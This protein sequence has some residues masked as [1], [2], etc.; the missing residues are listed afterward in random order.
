M[1]RIHL[2]I[3]LLL[4]STSSFAQS[5]EIWEIQSNTTLSPYA[6]S[7]VTSNEN[8]VTA[9]G[10]DRF[11]IQCPTDR[12][13]NNPLT[14]DGMM[15][16]T[17]NN[18]PQVSVG[19]L[20]DVSGLVI[21][22]QALTEFTNQGLDYEIVGTA[23]LPESVL[24]N[25]NFP[26]TIPQAV[27]EL[28]RVEGML[29]HFENGITNSPTNN[30]GQTYVTLN[31]T[32]A[33][34]EA[35]IPFP[36]TTGLPVWDGNP[37]IFQM[38]IRRLTND[39]PDWYSGTTV[40][41]E[42]V[43]SFSDP[44]Y[45]F[46]PTT[47][48]YEPN[49]LEQ[50][51]RPKE[52]NEVSVGCINVYVLDA[53]EF[54]YDIR[55]SKLAKYIMEAMHAPDIIAFQEVERIQVLEDLIERIEELFPQQSNYTPY[56]FGGTSSNFSIE[57]G[58]LV[59]D[60]LTDVSVT[61]LGVN[62]QLSTG[63][64]LHDRP[65]LLLQ[66][67]F[68]TI[69]PTPVSVLNIHLRSLN[70]ITG[71]NEDYV[72][73]KRHEAA[74]SVAQMVQS[75][76]DD[77]LIVVGDYNAFNFSDGYVDVFGQISGLASAGA[78][79]LIQDIVD[80]PLLYQNELLAE[81]EQYSY[82]FRG[83]AQTLDHCLS[84]QLNGISVTGMEYVRGNSDHPEGLVNSESA[85]GVSDHDG[86][87]LFLRTDLMINATSPLAVNFSDFVY[88]NPFENGDVIS[89]DLEKAEEF[90][91]RLYSLDGHLISQQDLGLLGAGPHTI[92]PDFGDRNGMYVLRLVGK[93][94]EKSGF[95]F[96][97]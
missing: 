13:D 88:P 19:D 58:Y 66:A 84:T 68:A 80:P 64:T 79:Y 72:R 23:T 16:Y 39:S 42:G 4:L 26:S 62:E 74:V 41:A 17:G 90:S 44:S 27:A 36:G 86:F 59:N 45:V 93:E 63:G 73:L 75:R 12:S 32:R 57:N 20:V 47:Y 46:Y 85:Y 52:D 14:S 82:V 1:I 83:N 49:V 30:N 31:G 65:P 15:V 8:V 95:V 56:L 11:F 48:S 40:S 55:I 77:N 10:S 3:Y 29:V 60:K 5:L 18:T 51:V 6:N 21:E 50:A 25:N 71:S 91:L 28:E 24:L 7:Q 37:E 76:Q 96:F 67:S 97:P 89:F 22:Y 78:E 35:G 81:E 43:M 94:S 34:R 53:D 38:D 54:G 69:P 87:V 70:G 9:V 92:T 61:Q 33:F 2:F